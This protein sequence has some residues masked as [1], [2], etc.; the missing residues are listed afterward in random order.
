MYK[1]I[2]LISLSFLLLNCSFDNKTGIWNDTS[3]IEKVS[4]K[5][6]EKKNRKVVG[7]SECK[8]YYLKCDDTKQQ[9]IYNE[10]LEDIFVKRETFSSLKESNSEYTVEIEKIIMNKNWTEE[11]YSSLNNVPNINYINKKKRLHKSSKLSKFFIRS[12]LDYTKPVKPLFYNNNII[13]F[14]HKGTVYIYSLTTKK[15]IWEFNFYNKKFKKYDKKLFLAVKEGKIYVSDNL[16]YL[17]CLDM[18]KKKMLW[19]KN[20]GVPFRSNLKID[21][22][23]LFLANQDNIIFSVDLISGV[24]NWQFETT[25]T[26]LKADFKNNILIDKKN[27]NLFFYNTSGEFYSINYVNQKINWV[28]NFKNSSFGNDKTLFLSLPIVIKDNNFLIST[29]ISLLKYNVSSGTKEW[30]KA[31]EVALKP[32]INLNHVYLVTKTNLLVCI[33]INT[34]NVIWSKAIFDNLDIK[35]KKLGIPTNLIIAENQIIIFTSQG[36]LLNYDYK[37]GDLISKTRITRFGLGT[38]PIFANG[39]LFVYNKKYQL[40][41]F[42]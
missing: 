4:V 3:N 33:N 18:E 6:I 1:I 23:Q 41:K 34:G 5:K 26:F 30:D 14:D 13:S 32:T 31:I 40:L 24:K 8:F 15:K 2:L 20:Y 16:G 11:Y 37:S 39:H 22:N 7:Q 17:Y 35:K 10:N 29:N 21:E 19:A 9:I 25:L 27:N 42:E 36:F 38:D 28:L 12:N